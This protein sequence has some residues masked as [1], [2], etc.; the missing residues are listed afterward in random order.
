MGNPFALRSNSYKAAL[1]KYSIVSITDL[2]GKIIY[3]NDRFCQISKYRSEELIGQPHSIINSGYHPK[4]Y[5]KEMWQTIRKGEVWQGEV[6][7]V[8][9][10]GSIYWVN[11]TIVPLKDAQG[12]VEEYFS[13]RVDITERKKAESLINKQKELLQRANF[14]NSHQIRGPL[15]TMMGLCNLLQT[16]QNIHEAKE[17]ENLMRITLEEFDL[18]LQQLILDIDLEANNS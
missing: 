10:D 16:S 15:A 17:L 6:C 7:N 9:K 8:A 1:D 4:A 12:K 14:T 2:K 11:T 3:A 5:W 13:V 18:K